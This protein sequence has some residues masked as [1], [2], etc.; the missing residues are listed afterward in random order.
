LLNI[1]P[2]HLDRYPDVA[3]YAAAKARLFAAQGPD[4]FAVLNVD[5]PLVAALAPKLAAAVVPFSTRAPRPPG[6]HG[7]GWL[8]GGELCLRLPD[9]EEVVERYAATSPGLVGRHNLE[10][11]LAASLAARLMG[12]T[13]EEVRTVL[14]TF[15]PLPHRMIEV[16]DVDGV[17][18]YDDSKGTNV[19]AVVAALD[20]FPRPVVLI[21]G[22]RDK[23]GSYEPLARSLLKVGRAVVVIGEAAERIADALAES[24]PDLPVERAGSLAD[25]VAVARRL[26]RPGDAVVLSPGCSSFDMFR[27]YAERGDAFRAAVDR[28]AAAPGGRS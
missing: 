5:D 25:A 15:E 8:E 12:A 13:A 28:L 17:R 1:T 26:A 11:A 20:G 9:E 24:A 16:G 18:Y 21:A 3:G 4:D 6:Q 14:Q 23:G 10:N 22:G 19:G 2:D 27:N 7:A